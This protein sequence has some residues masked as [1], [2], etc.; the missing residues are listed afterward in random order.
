MARI[1]RGF[2]FLSRRIFSRIFSPHFFSSF[3]WEKVARK[4]LQENPRQNPPK[5]KPQKIPDTFL[6]RGLANSF[7]ASRCRI[8]GN[9]R[10]AILGIV[11]FAIRESVPLRYTDPQVRQF[12]QRIFFDAASQ[13]HWCNSILRSVGVTCVTVVERR[14]RKHRVKM[15]LANV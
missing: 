3:L 5:F 12:P 4:I 10:P 1:F 2:L 6:Q 7:F 13:R 9:S 11:R 14:R 15:T 8:S